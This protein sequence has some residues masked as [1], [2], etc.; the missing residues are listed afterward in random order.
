L[1][2]YYEW[3]LG[4]PVGVQLFLSSACNDNL[5]HGASVEVA[6]PSQAD[7]S[8]WQTGG[9]VPTDLDLSGGG[10]TRADFD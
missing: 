1:F 10:L 2:F 8:A 5:Y 4:P 3:A 7:R 6:S 9:V